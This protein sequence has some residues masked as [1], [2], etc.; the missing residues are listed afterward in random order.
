MDARVVCILKSY[1][2]IRLLLV[3]A[4]KLNIGVNKLVN[5][6]NFALK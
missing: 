6:I 1:N 3:W 4:F 2:V 5:K